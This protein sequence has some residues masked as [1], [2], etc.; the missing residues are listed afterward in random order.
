MTLAELEKLIEHLPE[1]DQQQ[2]LEYA[3][4]RNSQAI[5]LCLWFIALWL[6][7]GL[8]VLLVACR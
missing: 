8:I 5:V 2:V 1:A 3:R 4:K 7:L 6:A